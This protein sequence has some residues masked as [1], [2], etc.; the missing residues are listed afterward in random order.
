MDF[1]K[2]F[3]NMSMENKGLYHKLSIIFAFFFLI[4]LLGFAYF[5]VK[6]DLLQDNATPLFALVFLISSLVGYT[7]IRRIFDQILVTSKSMKETVAKDIKISEPLDTA[8]ELQGIAQSFHAIQ[9]ELLSSFHNLDR[10]VSQI[11]TLKELSDLCYVTFDAEDLLYITLERALKLIN[12]DIGSVLILDQPKRE[13]FILQANIGLGSHLQKGERIAFAD[14][15]A[16]YAVINKTP[17]LVEDIEKDIRFGRSNRSHYGTKSVLCMPLKGINE[18]IGVLTF[19]RRDS[20]LPFTQDD[21]DV[22]SPLLSSA[23]FTYDNLGLIKKN[24]AKDLHLKA[25]DEVHHL[26]SSSLS[27]SEVLSAIL[28]QIQ[29]DISCELVMVLLESENNPENLSVVD[30]LTDLP[31]TLSRHAE[32][33]YAGTAIERVIRQG[34]SSLI[35]EPNGW[36]HPIEAALFADHHLNFC[37]LSP[38]RMDGMVRGVLALGFLQPHAITDAQERLERLTDLAAL[39]IEKGLLS[40]FVVKREQE[41]AIIK[42]IGSLLAASTFDMQGVMGHTLDLIRATLDV[43]AGSLL[44]LDKG[45]L[46]FNVAFNVDDSI[47]MDLLRTIKLK[48]GQGIAGY[49]AARGEPIIVRNAR[50]SKQFSPEFDRITGFH[51]RSVLCVPLISQGQVVGVIEVINKRGG[52]FNESDMRLMQSIAT[53]VSIA[54]ENA[55]LYQETL[56]MAENERGIRNMFQKFV[57]KEIVDKITHDTNGEKPVIDELKTLTLMNIDLRGFSLLAR[58]LGPHK[59]VA[60]LNHFFGIMGGI[61]F[62]HLGIVDKYLGDGFLALFGAPVSDG[63]DAD[64][65]IAAALEMKAAIGSINDYFS[66]EIVKPLAIGI[67]IHTG[68]AVVGNI[69]FEKKMDYTVIGDAVNV[70]FSLQ[71]LTRIIPN[72]IVVSEKTLRALSKARP[73]V[74]EMGSCDAGQGLE[75]LKTYELMGLKP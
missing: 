7:I 23:A 17:L 45:D 74:R 40:A 64:H 20:A 4:P 35:S 32:Y 71:D 65:A 13:A 61:V 66:G 60:V 1:R 24:E 58:E 30:F 52:D 34:T 15:I 14:S 50:E 63:R 6:Y 41:M 54:L 67:S 31:T 55:R 59:T 42:Q 27:G 5:A 18:V 57:P 69:G 3:K 16:K 26:L 44:L 48:L 8:S 25:L 70:V 12:A 36:T 75:E 49:C 11:S 22:L 10:R 68:E 21:A 73:K 56:L 51:T 19:S 29:S 9:T 2:L 37:F 62:K 33:P 46:V 38:L 53:S 43:E 39:T 28:K 47:T 72:G